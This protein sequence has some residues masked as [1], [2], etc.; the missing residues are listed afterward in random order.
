[1]P[2]IGG[3][4]A[5][6]VAGGNPSGTS[7][8]LQYIGDHVYATSGSISVPTAETSLIDATTAGNSYILADIQLSSI[9]KVS[10]D[11]DLRIKIN[12]EVVYGLQIDNTGYQSFLYGMS[13][14]QLIIA[15]Q[16][17]IE[18]TLTNISQDVGREWF[19]N[20]TGRVYA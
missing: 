20:L 15:P 18:V 1:M 16:T 17:R 13:P 2:L 4:G 9:D 11:F 10:D 12:G 8:N 14:I 5:G 19:C 6:N 7:S 3:G